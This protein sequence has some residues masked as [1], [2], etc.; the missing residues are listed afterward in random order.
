M[1]TLLIL[2][3]SKL[4]ESPSLLQMSNILPVN[5]T[6]LELETMDLSQADSMPLLCQSVCMLDHFLV[7]VF[8]YYVATLFIY[9]FCRKPNPDVPTTSEMTL[10]VSLK[11][12][13]RIFLVTIVVKLKLLLFQ[14]YGLNTAVIPIREKCWV[15]PLLVIFPLILASLLSLPAFLMKETHPLSVV[16][17]VSLCNSDDF[18]YIDVYQS[19]VVILGYYLPAAIIIFLT[20]CLSIRRCCNTCQADTCISSFCKEEMALAILSVPHILAVQ[21]LYLPN[22]DSFLAK[23]DLST[24]GLQESIKQTIALKEMKILFLY[25]AYFFNH[26]MIA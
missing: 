9:L 26:L 19:S 7:V 13:V 12:I 16:P 17:E 20:W 18:H 2:T 5:L 8:M 21:I 11:N 4:T 14:L 3:M 25:F 6:K 10:R 22:L 24:T 15:S 23:L 1:L